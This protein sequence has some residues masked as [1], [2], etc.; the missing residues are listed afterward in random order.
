MGKR[1]LTDSQVADV[2][3]LFPD[4]TKDEIHHLTG[5]SRSSID[6]IQRINHLYKSKEH[7][8]RMGVRAGTAS[9]I[10]RGGKFIGNHTPEANAKRSATYKKLYQMEDMRVRWGLEQRTKIRLRHGCHR[11]QDQRCYLRSLGYIVDEK[12]FIAYY[13]D[14]TH[15]AS[16][17]E[18]L[19][20][21]EKRGPYH[22]FYDFKPY[23][24]C[25]P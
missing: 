24:S 10:A 2:I 6:R 4:H 20:R 5:V 17:L 14:D 9:N 13:T 3:R 11:E 19:K 8:S 1:K 7:L 21:G 23:E 25:Q 18:K 15:R 12:K 16:R 22:C